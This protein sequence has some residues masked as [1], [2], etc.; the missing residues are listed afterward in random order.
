[1]DQFWCQSHPPFSWN[2]GV[3]KNRETHLTHTP[4]FIDDE[5]QAQ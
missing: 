1:M 5:L 4:H 3:G 2:L